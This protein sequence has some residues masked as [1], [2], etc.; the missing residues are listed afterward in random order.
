MS[1]ADREKNVNFKL[2]A[3]KIDQVGNIQPLYKY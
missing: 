2:K 3:I 1:L